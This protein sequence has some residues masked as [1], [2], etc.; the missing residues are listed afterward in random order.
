MNEDVQNSAQS[1]RELATSLEQQIAAGAQG[2]AEDTEPLRRRLA[3]LYLR[4]LHEPGRAAE[5]ARG[6]LEGGDAT[7]ETLQLANELLDHPS[8]APTIA[9]VLSTTYARLGDAKAEAK[10]LAVEI[11]SSRP[12]RREAARKRLSELRFRVFG[13]TR[14]ALDLIEPL[15]ATDPS[16]D[17]LRR[18]YMEIAESVGTPVR[19]AETLRRSFRAIKDVAA[20][21]RVGFDIGSLYLR[22]GE[23]GRARSAFLDVVL[24]NGSA[25]ETVASARR[26]LDMEGPS[27]DAG[28][29]GAALD[30]IA[31]HA[32][33]AS[34]REEAA[35]RLLTLH[36]TKPQRESRVVAA[37]EALTD[38]ARAEEALRWLR[39]HYEKQNDAARLAEVLRKLASRSKDV[40]EG[41][42]LALE[43]LKLRARTGVSDADSWRGFLSIYGPHH[44]AHVALAEIL[45]RDSDWPELA[46]VLEADVLVAPAAERSETLARLGRVRLSRLDDAEAALSS[47]R[48]CLAEDSA[49][50]RALSGVEELMAAG[51]LR[52]QAADVL[53]GV[54]EA[55]G[56]LEG[57]ARVLETR[58]ELV[59]DEGVRLAVVRRAV[60][61]V[62]EA[63]RRDL[64]ERVCLRAIDRDPSS[65]ALHA[66]L[67]DL[68]RGS[69]KP[70]ERLARYLAAQAHASS[71]ERR[72][73]LG[74]AI[75]AI[76]CDDLGD[77]AGSLS[78]LKRIVRENPADVGAH[79]ALIDAAERAGDGDVLLAALERARTALDG[80]ARQSMTLRLA[81]ELAGRGS[82]DEALELCIELLA[83]ESVERDTLQAVADLTRD[84]NADAVYRTA[85]ERLCA[86]DAGEDRRRS[87]ELLGDFHY[88]KLGDVESAGRL[89]KAAAR[90]TGLD[91][92]GREQARFLYD[93]VLQAVPND[94]EAAEALVDHYAAQGDWLRLPE[95]LR[96]VVHS[97]EPERASA[98][99]LLL[100]QSAVESRS[101]GEYL[102]LAD[103]LLERLGS[104][105]KGPELERSRAR[106]LGSDLTR[107]RDASEAFRKLVSVHERDEDVREYERFIE[108]IPQADFRHSEL[109]WLFD[110][111]ATHT[112][113]PYRVLLEWATAEED[114]GE[115]EA[116]VSVYERIAALDGHAPF[117]AEALCRLRLKTGDFIGGLAALDDVRLN[118]PS[119][120]Q[121]ELNL[122]MARTLFEDLARPVEA[123]FAL[124]P[125]VAVRPAVAEVQELARRILA[126]SVSLRDVIAQFEDVTTK[127]DERGAFTVFEF[128]ISARDE[129]RSLPSARIR[130]LQRMLD[131]SSTEPET[132]LETVASGVVEH[133]SSL[134][135]W[136]GFETLARTM[137]RPRTLADAY[138]S[139][140]LHTVGDPAVADRL[141]KR[142][143]ALEAEFGISSPD[144]ASALACLLMQAPDSRW[145]FDRVKLSLGAQSRWDDLFA[146][147]DRVV[148]A[149]PSTSDRATLLHE[150]ALAARDLAAKPDRAIA[151]FEALRA[152]RRDDT[153]IESTL[154]RLYVRQGRTRSLI[155]LLSE[156]ID[157]ET[158][159]RLRELRHRIAG[160]W[161]DLGNAD[162]AEALATRM[163]DSGAGI[164]DVTDILERVVA[165][166][167][168]S[169]ER[170]SESELA[171]QWRALD[172][173][174]S[175]YASAGRSDEV[176]RLVEA[177][178]ALAETPARRATCIRELVSLRL[179]QSAALQAPFSHALT[180]IELG[181]AEDLF[182]A[183][184]AYRSLLARTLWAW[185]KASG[186]L[187]EDAKDTTYAVLGRL[188]KVLLARGDSQGAF[189]LLSRA[190]ALPFDP[191]RCR[192][193]RADAAAV[194]AA[195]LG[196]PVGAI[197]ILSELFDANAAD[198][199]AANS[200]T[201]FAG[202][203]EETGRV[204][205]LARLWEKQGRIRASSRPDVDAC[206]CWERAAVLWEGERAWDQSVAA[207]TEGAALGSVTCYEALARIHSARQSW[208][209]AAD[210]LEWLCVNSPPTS[211]GRRSLELSDV[212]VRLGNRS[213]ARSSLEETIR[214]TPDTDR[215]RDVRERLIVLCREDNIYKPLADLLASEA[216]AAPASE[217]PRKLAYLCEAADLLRWKLDD[218]AGAADLLKK[219][220]SWSPEDGALRLAFVDVLESLQRWDEVASVLRG[221]LDISRDERPRDRALIHQRLAQALVHSNRHSDALAELRTADEMRP[222]SPMILFDLGRV[223][224]E[225][226][227]L[228]LSEATYRS[229]LLVVPEEGAA[230]PPRAEVFLDLAEIFRRRGDQ[231]RAADLVDSAFEE[232]YRTID[233]FG[234]FEESLRQRKRFDL[235]ARAKERRVV[236][237]ATLPVR[238][239]A[240]EEWVAVWTQYLDRRADVK[241]RMVRAAERIAR[242]FREETVTDP[243][244]WA[245][246]SRVQT[247]LGDEAA[248]LD[249]IQKRI[250]VLWEAGTRADGVGGARAWLHEAA[251]LCTELGVLDRAALIYERLVHDDPLDFEAW[252]GLEGT[253]RDATSRNRLYGRLRSSIDAVPSG[254]HRTRLRLQ[255]ANALLADPESSASAVTVLSAAVEEDPRDGEA[256]RLLWDVL[257]RDEKVDDLV[258]A[259]SSRL[260]R[261]TPVGDV[262]AVVD[263]SLRLGHTLERAG[264][265]DEART[266]YESLLEFDGP[267]V[268]ERTIELALGDLDDA[269]RAGTASQREG[270]IEFL[271]SAVGRVVPPAPDALALR[272]AET[273]A[274]AHRPDQ[275]RQQL[276]AMLTRNPQNGEALRSL[277]DLMASV[278]D[279]A[280]AT[281][282]RRRLLVD[283]LDRGGSRGELVHVALATAEAAGNCNRLEHV[284]KAVASALDVLAKRP[285]FVP[286]LVSLCQAIGAWSR[287]AEVLEAEASRRED[288]TEKVQFL[289]QAATT[290]LEHGEDASNAHRVATLVRSLQPESLDGAIVLAKASIALGHTDEAIQVLR[291]AAQRVRGQRS[292]TASIY[293]EIGKAYLAV[294]DLLEA[295]EA[296]KEAF[297]ADWRT[298]DVALL[299]GQVS[300]DIGDEK[301]AERALTAVT[302]LP[303]REG[304]AKEV[305][306]KATGFYHLASIAFAKG[307]LVKA[308]LLAAKALDLD[309]HPGARVLLMRLA[310]ARASSVAD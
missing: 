10:A 301:T 242:D 111:R 200:L 53:E 254:P 87:L 89:W 76:Q 78:T 297:A 94:P 96:V 218:S 56:F 64:A 48:Q 259:L 125:A 83:A 205:E 41:R 199:V 300:I 40:D 253:A 149:T 24:Q 306:T 304:N 85:L 124:A 195:K 59:E 118:T 275:A 52:L 27:G 310:Q 88:S 79:E 30:V 156:R 129:T 266:A 180:V 141:G 165:L 174:K 260:D 114:Y 194:R 115:P 69:E 171:P 161:L 273:L 143:V 120:E 276:E 178:L 309:D 307:D 9:E 191:M 175:Y 90:I 190:S 130:W 252:R 234:P 288:A 292:V 104:S 232:A 82:R 231:E 170:R 229:L 290:L 29:L 38:S 34:E 147:Y 177:S 139:A 185:R 122:R 86:T 233:D 28:V 107:E 236:E 36:A 73:A 228:D 222:G 169:Q 160:L 176:V 1:Y 155:E 72:I 263:T 71:A 193:L 137:D 274:R 135:L 230:Q 198:E 158:G 188:A 248:R 70:S 271:T 238:A 209:C 287:L 192:T 39:T 187:T 136:E 186:P 145:A 166:A 197:G 151:Y 49:N 173:L 305:S 81:Q 214:E 18:L 257:E 101:Q 23:L 14:G 44:E 8:V 302:T 15:V 206:A 45:E 153:S 31:R 246:L 239:V 62:G 216:D 16:T 286:E 140:L 298:R 281:D 7:D 285:L 32:P 35:S 237:A 213:R 283:V 207:Y 22:D 308:K 223:A 150:A 294:D 181:V 103:G 277:S 19:A 5:H 46:R 293:V 106:V 167:R 74:F 54:Y 179:E 202:L 21:E 65:S 133:P 58:A 47:F 225:L 240:L 265:F 20:R 37:Y 25:P 226:G 68:V 95:L 98:L 60:V 4:I 282:I 256:N 138:R 13:D 220:V 121:L 247:A 250:D 148:P 66:I 203:L 210:A 3:S 110:W 264:R 93:R 144:T 245:V 251:G 221:T 268:L 163:L 219:A 267:S 299:L 196:D 100:E 43:S 164:A 119:E 102:T 123:A 168:D 146:L 51:P 303:V 211:R 235:L 112:D 26:L 109:R 77:L 159:F 105:S 184:V 67:D 92:A 55:S 243:I 182:L 244:A 99:L 201:M 116:A 80:M 262:T 284:H 208:E 212:C 61:A 108:G 113:D 279:W 269:A 33:E 131:L 255:F 162:E 280:A 117:A 258:A 204:T 132:A 224:L 172:R 12:P 6:L 127:S 189:R 75:A 84:E 57:K 11:K 270:L 217:L 261:L 2:L 272:L 278:G 134:E 97:L 17:E 142:L 295:A 154:D 157:R 296:L 42:S 215:A 91:D 289:L 50:P 291:E 183:T 63:G 152:I 227:E 249:T 128:L 126:D 241:E